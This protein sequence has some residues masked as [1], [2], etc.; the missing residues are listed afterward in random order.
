MSTHIPNK[1]DLIDELDGLLILNRGRALTAKE[2]DQ[3]FEQEVWLIQGVIDQLK[4]EE[5]VADV[6]SQLLVS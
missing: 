5:Y 3:L 2:I 4:H 6:L 1:N